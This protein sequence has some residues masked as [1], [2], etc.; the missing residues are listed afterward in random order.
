MARASGER[1]KDLMTRFCPVGSRRGLPLGF[2][3]GLLDGVVV[4]MI[5]AEALASEKDNSNALA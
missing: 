2:G 1:V 3:M 5:Y 4:R